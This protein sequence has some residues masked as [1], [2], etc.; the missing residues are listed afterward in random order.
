MPAE[1]WEEA[2]DLARELGVNQV[3]QEAGLSYESLRRR[4]AGTRSQVSGSR[5]AEFVELAR[6]P[7]PSVTKGAV[8]FEIERPDGA[9][10]TIR[11]EHATIP[12]VARVAAAFAGDRP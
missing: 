9:R 7:P 1:L 3:R 2:T 10:L 11:L 8:T 4:V 6:L 5:G 12:D